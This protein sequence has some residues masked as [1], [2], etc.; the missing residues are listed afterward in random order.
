MDD[1]SSTREKMVEFREKYG[2]SIRQ[3]A[4]ICGTSSDIL[5]MVEKGDVTHPKIVERIRK[6]YKLTDLEAEELLPINR[7]PHGGDYDP[8]RYVTEIDPTMT[9]IIPKQSV[10]DAYIMEHRTDQIKRHAK[11][12]TYG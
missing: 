7:R 9:A 5:G 1:L 4:E 12:S 10:I 8:D 6:G 2:L 3:M 11:R